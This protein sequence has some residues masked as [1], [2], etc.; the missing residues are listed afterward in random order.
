MSEAKDA[1]GIDIPR[2]KT[3]LAFEPHI[4]ERLPT[5]DNFLW[6]NGNANMKRSHVVLSQK[7]QRIELG[8][9]GM[10]DRLQTGVRPEFLADRFNIKIA[11]ASL[12]EAKGNDGIGILVVVECKRNLLAPA[13]NFLVVQ[14]LQI[15]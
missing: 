4:E 3:R 14:L 5:Q 15:A 2:G 6:S 13:C 8:G 12:C 10:E 1:G 9:G 11:D 7:L